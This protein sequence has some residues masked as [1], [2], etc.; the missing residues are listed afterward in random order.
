MADNIQAAVNL[1]QN[2]KKKGG[3]VRLEE[4]FWDHFILYIASLILALTVLN[5][6]VEFL[7]GG[8]IFCFPPTDNAAT[9]DGNLQGNRA[10]EFGVGQTNYI[11]NFCA[12]SIKKTEDFS[13]YILL[14]GILLLVPH[15]L[16]N[17][18]FRGDF[19]SFFSI[20][21]KLDYFRD[22]T[23]EYDSKKHELVRQLQSK[24]GKQ[25]RIF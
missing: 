11:N 15:Y 18:C 16:W 7:R 2:E 8:G 25:K 3:L 17:A 23:G 22:D 13:I 12:R 1:L 9:I 4:F 19:G 10:H 21:N 6:T 20:V 24:Y 5:V 14:H